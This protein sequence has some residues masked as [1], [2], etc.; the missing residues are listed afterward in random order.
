MQS[1][2]SGLREIHRPRPWQCGTDPAAVFCA[3]HGDCACPKYLTGNPAQP[4]DTCPLHG[5]N[6]DHPRGGADG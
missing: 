3:V 2:K 1:D 4:V 6:T 5:A